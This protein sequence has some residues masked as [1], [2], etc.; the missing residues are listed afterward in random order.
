MSETASIYV[1][2]DWHIGHYV[3]VLMD[4]VFGENS[5]RREIIWDFTVLSGFKVQA[6]NWIRGHD[7]IFYYSIDEE[8]VFN[9]LIQP[10]TDEYRAMFKTDSKGRLAMNSAWD[11]KVLG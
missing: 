11:N 1:H 5:F 9:K 2:L 3:K 6:D 7:S 8:N 10:H 4:E